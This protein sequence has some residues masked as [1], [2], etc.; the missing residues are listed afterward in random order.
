MEP[1]Q[2]PALSPQ[3]SLWGEWL[4][5]EYSA[6]RLRV[7]KRPQAFWADMGRQLLTTVMAVAIAFALALSVYASAWDTGWLTWP[8]VALFLAVA[9]LGLFGLL[10]AIRQAIAGV[11]LEVDFSQKAL[12]GMPLSRAFFKGYVAT[13]QRHDLRQVRAVVLHCHGAE[14]KNNRTMCELVVELNDGQRLQ[15]PDVFAPKAMQSDARERL[16]PL[17]KAIAE[18][19]NVPLRLEAE[20]N[21][22]DDGKNGTLPT[23][24]KYER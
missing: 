16:L 17:A 12:W 24:G 13:I 23:E 1:T 19:A 11:R 8:L 18:M 3:H 6:T 9:V 14:R 22:E 21:L 5:E 10:R 15:G 4:L 20:A 2:E 7:G